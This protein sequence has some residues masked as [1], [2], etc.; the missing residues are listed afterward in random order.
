ME[1]RKKRN[2]EIERNKKQ[3]RRVSAG[4]GVAVVLVILAG[5]AWFAFDA[6]RRSWIMTFE[7]QRI[8]TNELRFMMENQDWWVSPEEITERA[9]ADLI[10]SLTIIHHANRLNLGM[11]NEERDIL[12]AN[13]DSHSVL[14]DTRMAE[15]FS[16]G[17][18][19]E[20]LFDYYVPEFALDAADYQDEIAEYI[21]ARRPFY[22]PS[23]VMYILNEDLGVLLSVQTSVF[24][25]AGTEF[26]DFVLQYCE[27][28]IAHEIESPNKL[29]IAELEGVIDP[30][31]MLMLMDLQ[32]GEMS[33]I[34][35]FNDS[36]LLLYM[37]SRGEIA[38]SE[39][40]E[41]FLSNMAL[42]LRREQFNEIFEEL[43]ENA[44]VEINQRALDSL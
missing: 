29:S 35:M 42:E 21:E 26:A 7:G 43:V 32:P 19:F 1:S 8:P 20:R 22:A 25:D 2:Q 40:Q 31:D 33:E 13:V 5:I 12:L 24:D 14:S 23:E 30:M 18:M 17:N 4:I 27:E 11:T 37:Y 10:Q 3:K 28:H 15:F 36:F 16:V 39:I 41:S 44:A 38:D 9:M 6:H 34:I